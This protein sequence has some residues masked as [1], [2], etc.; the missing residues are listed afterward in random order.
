VTHTLQKREF[1]AKWVP[2]HLSEEQRAAS[3]KVAEELLWRYKAEGERF[4]KRIVA[5]DETWISDFEPE[6]KS[7]SSYRKHATSP[8]QKKCRRRL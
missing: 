8:R 2:R 6:L 1:A 4:L 3:K 5:M 7:Q